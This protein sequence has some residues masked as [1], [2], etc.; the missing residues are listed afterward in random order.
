MASHF[1]SLGMPVATENDFLD[2]ARRA[3]E[4]SACLEAGP[5]GRYLRWSCPSGAELWLQVNAE[6]ELVGMNPHFRGESRVRVGLTARVERPQGTPLEGAF[7]G[8][9]D[10]PGDAPDGGAYPFVFDSPDF[11]LNGGIEPPALVEA[12]VVAFAHE[13]SFHASQA[14]YYN[15]QT[16]ELRFADQSFIPAGL[17]ESGENGPGATAIF[18]GHVLKTDERT[19]RLT[20]KP[21]RWALVRTL[22]GVFDVVIDPTLLDQTPTAGGLLSGSFWLSGRLSHD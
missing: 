22:G 2:L 21:F 14:D 4:S 15:A 3:S 6:N 10:P 9:A 12:Q 11:L 19:N 18:T 7:H 13:V 8:W 17:F 1:S 20:G 5:A 16:S